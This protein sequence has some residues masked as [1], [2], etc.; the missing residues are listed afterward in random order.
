MEQPNGRPE[1]RIGQSGSQ[2]L[3]VEVVV[4]IALSIILAL[5]VALAGSAMTVQPAPTAR[6]VIVP[7]IEEKPEDPDPRDP[8]VRCTVFETHTHCVREAS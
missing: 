1:T 3:P 5:M 8:L 7:V 2:G 6:T 4:G